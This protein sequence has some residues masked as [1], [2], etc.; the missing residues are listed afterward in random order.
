MAHAAPAPAPVLAR[1]P[2]A[3]PVW[4]P[5]V[6]GTGITASLLAE[7]SEEAGWLQGP[8][9]AFFGLTVLLFVG[10]SA[11]FAARCVRRRSALT[12]TLRDFSQL[13]Y[14]G[15][16]AM[17]FLVVGHAAH[18]VLPLLDPG[19]LGAAVRIDAVLWTVGTVL[20]LVT[21]FGF[22]AAIIM[23]EPGKPLP[24]WGLPLVPPM[25][26]ATTGSALVPFVP[27]EGL[28]LTLVV[29]TV[30]CF[31]VTL[32]L[33][34]V[35]FAVALHHH[36]RVENIPLDLAIS[37]WI[38]LGV[39]GQSMSAAQTLAAQAEH[40]VIPGAVSTLHR[41]ADLYGLAMVPLAFVTIAIAVQIT[42]Q[43]FRHGMRFVPGWWSLTFPV[44][45]L[46]LGSR[47]L[48]QSLGSGWLGA[49]SVAALV[50]LVI[51]WAFCAAS[52]VRA[53]LS[54]RRRAARAGAAASGTRS[55]EA[56][57]NA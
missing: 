24:T 37:S 46:A 21:A 55:P 50:V 35:I 11:G 13:P 33:G 48:A 2:E 22:T 28:R 45:T 8:S 53:F 10:L 6:M 31:A 7:F 56:R 12:S 49:L 34:F 29:L 47:L 54:V 20:G 39:L 57:A 25:G 43:G 17:A 38:P 15:A 23:G 18:V 36:I 42:A 30:G 26:S 40:F 52:S 16:V 41:L 32:V 27:D 4:F 19:A 14:W 44:G 9:V 1:F 51:N 5:S 3:G